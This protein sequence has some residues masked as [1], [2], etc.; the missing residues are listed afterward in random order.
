[1]NMGALAII[2]QASPEGQV[3]NHSIAFCTRIRLDDQQ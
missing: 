2:V 3:S 1:M